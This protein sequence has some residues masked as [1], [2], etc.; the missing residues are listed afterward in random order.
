MRGRERRYLPS[1]SLSFLPFSFSSSVSP[2]RLTFA[3]LRGWQSVDNT[4]GQSYSSFVRNLFFFFFFF[5]FFVLVFFFLLYCRRWFFHLELSGTRSSLRMG[6]FTRVPRRTDDW[7]T[8]LFPI[9]VSR[10]FCDWWP[11]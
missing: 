1:L 6:I 2:S 8:L 9:P 11:V 4:S 5:F 3:D 7:V 10:S